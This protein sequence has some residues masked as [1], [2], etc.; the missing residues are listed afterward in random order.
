MPTS[1]PECD[2][3][4]LIKVGYGVERVEDEINR[5][6]PSARTLRLDSDNSKI[7]S[8]LF[9]TITS[10]K[11]HE[12]DILIGTQMI[13]KG[14]DF[15]NVTLVGVVLADIGLS[16]P[17][18]RSAE[19]AFQLIT[20][21]IGRA[22]RSNKKGEAVVQTYSPS[23]YSIT[24]AARQNYELF[25]Y[26][27]MKLRKG[28]Y[29]PPYCYMTSV[30]VSGKT[31]DNVVEAAYYVSQYLKEELGKEAVVLGPSSPFI[32]YFA[33]KYSRV[34]LIKYKNGAL[35]RDSLKA[36]TKSAFLKSSISISINIDPYD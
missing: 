13:A 34:I 23:H 25:Y 8:K 35:I 16:L 7:K 29:Y 2:S 6:F 5:L 28:Q 10:F 26:T 9:K 22:G 20:Q 3:S 31:E 30:T 14:H 17:N 19:R 1:C 36:L 15:E 32:P 12:A 21:A 4:Y 33:G 24:L 11:N 18:Y 27:E